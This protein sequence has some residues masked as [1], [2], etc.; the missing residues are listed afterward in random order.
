[1]LIGFR[2]LLS[3]KISPEELKN[4]CRSYEVIGNIAVLRNSS[5]PEHLLT[6]VAKTVTEIN[7]NIKTVLC[8][9]G[10]VTGSFRL[11][12]LKWIH[13]EKT[14]E[15][16]HREFDCLFKVN[17]NH[18]YFSPRLS[19]ERARIARQT[20]YHET[21]LN[22]F[23]GVGCFSIL[24]A[25]LGKARK[26]YS[27]DINP[28]AT[29]FAR[30]NCELNKIANIVSIFE[31]D[32]KEI[33]LKK[34]KGVADRVLMPLPEKAFEYLEY[35]VLALKAGNSFIHYYGFVHAKVN[36]NPVEKIKKKVSDWLKKHNINFNII[37]SR[38][39]RTVGPRWYQ[40]VLDIMIQKK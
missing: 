7:K 34:M 37:F 32:A 14:T 23:G 27:I 20:E 17:L 13:G 24:I 38:K 11:R 22:M 2:N 33:I 16:I 31:G 26:F 21:V 5:V 30:E 9:V 10:P 3:K 36:E 4:V 12:K 6:M 19:Y 8:Q 1:V 28:K 25:K 40:I 35:A 29:Q 39:V 15:T 18:S